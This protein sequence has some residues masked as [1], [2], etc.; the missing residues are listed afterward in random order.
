MPL[1][2]RADKIS[3][4]DHKFQKLRSSF[5]RKCSV[6]IMYES[7]VHKLSELAVFVGNT[8]EWPKLWPGL[9]ILSLLMSHACLGS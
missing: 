8:A 5:Q 7:W 4:A 3:Y 6:I 9:G 2:S 1:H